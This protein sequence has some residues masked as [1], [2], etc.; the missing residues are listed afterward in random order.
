[1]LML[2]TLLIVFII[3][4]SLVD[5]DAK[6]GRP[7]HPAVIA[8]SVPFMILLTFSKAGIFALVLAFFLVRLVGRT[9][10]RSIRRATVQIPKP[11]SLPPRAPQVPGLPHAV[12]P[13]MEFGQASREF[14]AQL[15]SF[16]RDVRSATREGAPVRVEQPTERP[17]KRA[18]TAAVLPDFAPHSGEVGAV[19]VPVSPSVEGVLRAHGALLPPEA[20]AKIRTL[21]ARVDETNAYLKARGRTEGEHAFLLR[22]TIDDYLPGVV[23]AYARLPRSLADTTPLD[24]GKTG[25]D[26]LLEQLDLLERGVTDILAAAA[27][28]EGQ[29]LLANGRFLKDRFEGPKGKDFEI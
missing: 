17:G 25:K 16:L 9:T 15:E 18:S 3:L 29:D 21:G 20:A 11:P 23:A 4:M 19:S 26:L 27:K 22:Q 28:A 6:R 10:A 13:R 8:L 1:M 12:E 2:I 7:W 24:E 5:K 14:S